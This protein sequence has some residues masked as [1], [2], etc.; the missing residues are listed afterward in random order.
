MTQWRSLDVESIVS[1]VLRLS[2][3]AEAQADTFHVE[4]LL[5]G[6]NPVR[7]PP[8]QVDFTPQDAE[9][10]RWYLEDYLAFPLNPAPQR[11]ARIEERM[12]EI[13]VTLFRNVFE[14]NEAMR[15]AWARLPDLNDTRIE[16][17]AEVQHATAIPWELLRDPETDKVLAVHARAFVRAASNQVEPPPLPPPQPSPASQ[18]REK[19]RVLLVICRPRAGDDVPFRSVASR[20][21]KT[22][23]DEAREFVQLDVLR[24]PTIEQLSAVL[25][26]AKKRGQPYHIVHFD[27]HGVYEEVNQLADWLKRLSPLILGAGGK[28]GFLIF[29]NPAR[30]DNADYIDGATLGKVLTDNDVPALVLN[31]C[32]SAFADPPTQPLDAN[33]AGDV[34]QQVRAFGSF[35]QAVTNAGV[36]GVVA[37]RYTLYV[38]TAKEFVA[39]LYAALA[40][41]QSL[42]QAVTFG[43][44]QLALNPL[45]EIA[46]KPIALQDWAVPIVYEAAEIEL[47]PRVGAFNKTPLRITSNLQSPTSNLQFDLPP[48]PDIEFIGRD[49]T[50]LALDRAFDS[51][52]IVLLHAFAGSGKTTTAVEFAR[53][54]NATGGIGNDIFFTSFERRK[55]LADALNETIGRAFYDDLEQSGVHWLTL[56]NEQRRNVALQVMQQ[57]PMLWIWDNVEPIA[58]F[59]AGTPSA[60][61]KEEQDELVAFLRAA[62]ETQAKFLLTSRRDER[63]WLGDLPRRIPVPPMPMQE[64]VELARALG[65][66]YGQ[67]FFEV[68]NWRPLLKFTQGNPLTIT[69]VVGVA[70]RQGIKSRLEIR[71]FVEKLRAGEQAFEDEQSE[72][73]SKSLGAS[74]SYGFA[75]A[76]TETEHKQLALLHLFQGFVNPTIFVLVSKYV[77]SL[78]PD[79]NLN[80][81]PEFDDETLNTSITLLSRAAEVGLLSSPR[82]GV[83][84][85]H[86]ALPWFLKKVFD[87]HYPTSSVSNEEDLALRAKKAFVY[88]VGGFTFYLVKQARGILDV[89]KEVS[90]F[91]VHNAPVA[92]LELEEPNL[93]HAYKIARV[94]NWLNPTLEMLQALR[95]I[96]LRAEL[97]GGAS[98]R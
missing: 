17:V 26:A 57:V 41:G 24:P 73:R 30:K 79:R 36:A 97:I 50:L 20:I 49:E 1:H 28:H 16:I 35:A 42:G 83:F 6:R 53:W 59:P 40:A 60:W 5:D 76:F 13:G 8:F 84:T 31:A 74:L 48:R 46:F 86:P 87:Q 95:T 55:T 78:E 70:L 3:F 89:P 58:G 34:G 93:L 11:A 66:K 25:D 85:I 51:Q 52:R 37:M 61:S 88:A 4:F 69:V 27:G 81:D 65:K 67:R 72:A 62:R 71:D 96:L 91:G 54:Y 38:E 19:I 56:T 14:S 39:N 9:D 18:G 33:S 45:R 44:K 2:Q 75:S 82:H 12:R 47:F 92:V 63:G 64:R 32:R 29:E 15:R 77:D 21:V 7:T 80:Q 68:E 22:L 94:H 98:P 90:E 43:R 10:L 23:S